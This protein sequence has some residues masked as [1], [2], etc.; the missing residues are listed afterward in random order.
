MWVQVFDGVQ[1]SGWT[2]LSVNLINHTPV[3]TASD[4]VATK[5][6][7]FAVSSLFSVSD[8]DA[9]D[10]VVKYQF[11]DSTTGPSSGS[12]MINGVSQDAGKAIE[13]S[14]AQLADTVFQ[15]RSGMDQLWVRVSDG[16]DWSAWQQFNVTAPIDHAANVTVENIGV[17]M[18]YTLAANQLFSSTDPD[19]DTVT[20]YEFWDSTADATSGHFSVGGVAQAAG[21][22]ISVDA[23]SISNVSFTSSSAP[24]TDQLWVRAFDGVLWSDWKSF[25]V[26]APAVLAPKV[27]VANTTIAKNGSISASDL[28]H[29]SVPYS[30]ES[31][32]AYQLWD[33]VSG[34]NSGYFVVN[35][36]AQAAGQRD[37]RVGFR[38]CPHFLPGKR[39]ELRQS[40][41]SRSDRK[42][43]EQLGALHRQCAGRGAC[44]D[45]R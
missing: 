33:D 40:L 15:S 22:A 43:L 10:S 14:A 42:H 16:M 30:S 41:G 39:S 25:T 24:G 32:T 17:A 5:G 13:V 11:W 20:Q 28:F 45:G 1:W 6:Q 23:S 3:V 2:Q 9:N 4:V 12:F 8:A 36:V 27:V 7:S 37:R 29:A 34:P 38:P 26:T 18:N 44:G 35:G 21:Q 31:V 19:G